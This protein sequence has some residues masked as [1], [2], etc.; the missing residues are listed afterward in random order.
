MNPAPYLLS[1]LSGLASHKCRCPSMM[2]SSS[3]PSV[4]N[5]ASPSLVK[6]IRPPRN[7]RCNRV[8]GNVDE[9]RRLGAREEAPGFD[10]VAGSG[11]VTT[12]LAER[13]TCSH[14]DPPADGRA[15]LL[16]M[17]PSSSGVNRT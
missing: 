6:V 15:I 2:N 16:L 8:G 13:A 11:R 17:S 1:W 10:E 7:P 4:L 14:G 9:R 3:P 5:T 12:E